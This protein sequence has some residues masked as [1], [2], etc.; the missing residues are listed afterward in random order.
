MRRGPHAGMMDPMTL[1][2]HIEN[3]S[4]AYAEEL[5]PDVAEGLPLVAALRDRPRREPAIKRALQ[6]C[7][8]AV[9]RKR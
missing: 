2:E 3:N 4:F 8:R 7:V 5:P 1:S 9:S 6:T